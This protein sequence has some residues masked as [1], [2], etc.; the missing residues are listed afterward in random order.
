MRTF[1]P[2]GGRV[3]VVAGRLAQA[4]RAVTGWGHRARLGGARR[5]LA[6]HHYVAPVSKM[7]ADL[8]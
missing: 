4:Q 6:W 3:T 8:M 1:R 2:A 5:D 7:M